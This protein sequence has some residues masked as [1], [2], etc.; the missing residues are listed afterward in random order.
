LQQW[1]PNDDPLV[2]AT[3]TGRQ[4][5]LLLAPYVRY[6]QGWR[7]PPSSVLFPGGLEATV[8]RKRSEVAEVGLEGGGEPLKTRA[9]YLVW[10]TQYHRFGG[11]GL[12]PHALV[13]P[14]QS[15]H[16]T[17]TGLREA[18]VEYLADAAAPLPSACERVLTR[19]QPKKKPARSHG[20]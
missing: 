7:V 4:V 2:A 13:E 5:A 9:S 17:A 14:T 20:K 3:L 10:M 6:A 1:I 11:G 12:A 18:V 15:T 16:V 8:Q 19:E